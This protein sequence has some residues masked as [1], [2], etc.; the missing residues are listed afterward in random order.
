MRIQ[1]LICL[2]LILFFVIYCML[3]LTIF[4]LLK[5]FGSFLSKKNYFIPCIHNT[6]PWVYQIRTRRSYSFNKNVNVWFS[7]ENHKKVWVVK[8]E[9]KSV[10]AMIFYPWGAWKTL[11]LSVAFCRVFF[12]GWLYW[13]GDVL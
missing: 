3:M 12:I 4:V 11:F 8:I 7:C 5:F 10:N 6:V 13:Q 1:E 9:T 2:C